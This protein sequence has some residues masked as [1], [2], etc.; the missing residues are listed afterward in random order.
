MDSLAG[1]ST[2]YCRCSHGILNVIPQYERKKIVLHPLC[3][4]IVLLKN[5]LSDAEIGSSFFSIDLSGNKGKVFTKQL[6]IFS[7]FIF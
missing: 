4:F 6:E 1:F 3:R 7:C 5:G 2:R